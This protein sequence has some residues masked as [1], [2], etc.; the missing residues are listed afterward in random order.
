MGK[1][2]RLESMP[3]VGQAVNAFYGKYRR[4][5]EDGKTL[6]RIIGYPLPHAILRAHDIAYMYLPSYAATSAARH[7]TGE[8]HQVAEKKG[9]LREVCS[10]VRANMGSAFASEQ[11]INLGTDPMYVMPK[12]DFI[13]VTESSC[14][15]TFT[16][17]QA[18]A[19]LFKVPLFVVHVPFVWNESEE[20]DSVVEVARQL[21]EFV[22]FL[23]DISGRKF[24]WDNYRKTMAIAKETAHLRIDT[25]DLACQAVPA[26]ATVFDWTSMLALVNYLI[27]LPEGRDIAQNVRQEVLQRMKNKEGAIVPEKYRLYWD[28]IMIWPYLGRVAKKCADLGVNA[29]WARYCSFSFW[30]WPDRIDLNNPL[31]GNAAQVVGLHFNRNIDWLIDNISERCRRYHIDGLLFHANLTCRTMAGPQLEIIDAVSRKLGIPAVYFEGDMADETL[32]S[33]SQM[34]TRIQALIE[35]IEARKGK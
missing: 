5:R 1:A 14:S 10:Y 4:A 16:W 24:D 28:G 3:S 30:Q 6:C 18:E 15:M 7:I 29:I 34:D 20:K 11:G 21:R 12:P 17:G 32:I 8:L 26:P 25:M 22:V 13:L 23:E 33:E 9:L 19:D 27:G 31:E 2:N 35:T